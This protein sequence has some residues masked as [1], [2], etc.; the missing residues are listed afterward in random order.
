MICALVS[1]SCLSEIKL[2]SNLIQFL[3]WLH[4]SVNVWLLVNG[5]ESIKYFSQN[6]R[7]ALFIFNILMKHDLGFLVNRNTFLFCF[8]CKKLKNASS[9]LSLKSRLGYK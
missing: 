1:W 4:F 3:F 5:K 6:Q 7:M 9:A 2:N 8:P